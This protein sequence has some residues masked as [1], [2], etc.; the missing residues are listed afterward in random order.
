MD[1]RSS[2]VVIDGLLVQAFDNNMALVAADGIV[3]TG[4]GPNT[5]QGHFDQ[6]GWWES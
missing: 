6:D 1:H 2:S 4:D 5:M 3:T